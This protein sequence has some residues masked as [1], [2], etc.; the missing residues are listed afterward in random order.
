MRKIKRWTI[1][2]AALFT[3]TFTFTACDLNTT[4]DSVSLS[5]ES[6][7]T[8]PT[9]SEESSLPDSS[10][11]EVNPDLEIVDA[12]YELA[13]GEYLE[14][15][16]TLTGVVTAVGTKSGKNVIT[17]V[18][19]ERESKPIYC[20]GITG[21][22]V[23]DLTIGDLVSVN[24]KLYNYK[25]TIEFDKG[26]VLLS[27]ESFGDAPSLGDDPYANVDPFAFYN[28][29]SPAVSNEDAYY[30]SLHGLMSGSLTVPDQAPIRSAYQ[31]TRNDRLIRNSEMKFSDD[32]NAY[33]VV[34]AYGNDAFTVYRQGAYITLEEVA[35]FVYAFGTYPANYTTSKN[36]SPTDSIWAEYLRLNHTSFSG[37]TDR[38]PY[39]PKLPNISGCGGTLNYFEMDIGTTGTDCDPS[40]PVEIY[41][42]GYDITRGAA[43]IVYGK[44]DLNGNGV[45][46]INEH[47]V[48][49]TYNHYNDF[50]EYL[51]YY[52]GWGEKFGNI[53]GG[54]SISSTTY[55][56]P[57]DYV[58]IY[59][60]PLPAF[61][62]TA[63]TRFTASGYKTFLLREI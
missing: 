49:Y 44:Y 7:S 24:G 48:F 47:H 39:E 13:V 62:Y 20:F 9:E 51:N 25:G 2:I 30:R 5:E 31:P 33:T 18:I 21:E 38:Y 43:R 59:L 40:Y 3:A 32:G 17:I 28:D 55:Y 58:E 41:N 29:Y 36:A 56:N 10:I 61:A 54:G 11:E 15:T 4:S 1:A 23:T 12:A 42:D 14:G 19:P 63:E 34:D 60:E 45:F 53:T 6:I 26:C 37:N 35:A 46:E 16:Y 22:G 50:E 27:R 52:G 8:L 57:T